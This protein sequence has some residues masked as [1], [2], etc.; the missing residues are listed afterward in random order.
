MRHFCALIGWKSF[1]W[2]G[3]QAG[4]QTRFPGAFMDTR[5]LSVV[6]KSRFWAKLQLNF[7]ETAVEILMQVLMCRCKFPQTQRHHSRG[8]SASADRC[9]TWADPR[10]QAGIMPVPIKIFDSDLG[11]VWS[12]VLSHYAYTFSSL[13]QVSG[14]DSILEKGT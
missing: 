10:L 11:P 2:F 1:L 5:W 3:E 4:S 7:C 9:N 12:F 14:H 13:L 6:N 8:R